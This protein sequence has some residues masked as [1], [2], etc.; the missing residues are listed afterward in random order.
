MA[1]TDLHEE[2]EATFALLEGQTSGLMLSGFGIL[3]GRSETN[4]QARER[5]ARLLP[6]EAKARRAY[7]AALARKYRGEARAKCASPPKHGASPERM[8]ELTEMRMAKKAADTEA[9]RATRAARR[10]EQRAAHRAR[11]HAEAATQRAIMDRAG[12]RG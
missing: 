12:E 10:R 1:F 3:L 4:A 9:Y 11:L 5:I 2:I 6:S 7:R 8:R